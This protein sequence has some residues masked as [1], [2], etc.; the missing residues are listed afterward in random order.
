MLRNGDRQPARSIEV[1][2]ED[3]GSMQVCL[4]FLSFFLHKFT[5][6]G[7]TTIFAE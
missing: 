5:E 3:K 1:F 7:F 4:C 6:R 2:K